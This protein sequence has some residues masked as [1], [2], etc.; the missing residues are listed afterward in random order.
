VQE[1]VKGKGTEVEGKRRFVY[2]NQVSSGSARRPG[3]PR[4]ERGR[5]KSLES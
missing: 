1:D 3:R 5:E 4:K 2:V